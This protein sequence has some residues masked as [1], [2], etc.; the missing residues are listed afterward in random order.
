MFGPHAA[1]N[2]LRRIFGTFWGTVGICL[3]R[4]KLFCAE[5]CP[6][7]KERQVCAPVISFTTNGV[8]E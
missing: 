2:G 3:G 6:T 1:E 5:V 7:L 8:C 4:E